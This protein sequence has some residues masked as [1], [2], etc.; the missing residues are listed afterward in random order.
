MEA[1]TTGGGHR[2]TARERS[3]SHVRR[4][5]AASE[6]APDRG[7]QAD[8]GGGGVRKEDAEGRR[9][10]MTPKHLSLD[11]ISAL[12]SSVAVDSV[13]F[14]GLDDNAVVA[15]ESQHR[16]EDSSSGAWSSCDCSASGVWDRT[17]DAD[18]WADFACERAAAFV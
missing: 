15:Q 10:S 4:A 6:A 3:A 1:Y 18:V 9:L 2:S 12:E 14:G 5:F 13:C 8:S 17:C 11:G 16:Q 7:W